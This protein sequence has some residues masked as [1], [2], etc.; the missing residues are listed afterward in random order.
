MPPLPLPALQASLSLVLGTM[1]T[2]NGLHPLNQRVPAWLPAMGWQST[3]PMLP[4][5]QKSP[6][7]K[8]Q[9]ALPFDPDVL[10]VCQTFF[11]YVIY[12]HLFRFS[13]GYLTSSFRK[14]SLI[15]HNQ[16]LVIN[17]VLLLYTLKYLLHLDSI[18]TV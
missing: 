18:N 11:F 3:L 15:C 1:V 4:F 17:W 7:A 16:P 10:S 8:S 6:L 12:T 9:E 2:V 14:S 5:S 13:S